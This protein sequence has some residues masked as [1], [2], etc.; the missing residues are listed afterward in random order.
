M[1]KVGIIG[2]SGYTGHELVKLLAAH[3]QVSLDFLTS[4]AF[5]G[6]SVSSVYPDYKGDEVYS[7]RS[8]EQI[9]ECQPDLVFLAV[10]HG[11]AHETAEQLS[12]IKIIDLSH[13]HR[14]SAANPGW[15]YGLPELFADKIKTAERV[16][17][18]GCYATASLLAVLPIQDY[19]DRIIFDCKSGWSGAGRTSKYADD[20]SLI[21]DNLIPYKLTTH[22]HKSEIQQFLKPKISLTPHVIDTFQGMLCT[23]HILLHKQIS[24]NQTIELYQSFYKDFPLIQVARE[25][26]N[27]KTTQGRTLSKI[28]GFEIDD[29]GRLV[30]VS[31]IDNLLK[32]A[33]SQA[34]QNMNLMLGLAINTGLSE[35]IRT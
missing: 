14:D 7:D 19:T 13:D 9:K 15:V 29:T 34:V 17:N 3:P 31:S 20:P 28:G 10:P 21:E 30:I 24:S 12:Q 33:A 16:A 2:A 27:I 1:Y 6:Q 18:P 5:A 35:D 32:G 25:A 4:R 26:P 11:V 23:A 22:P 8:P